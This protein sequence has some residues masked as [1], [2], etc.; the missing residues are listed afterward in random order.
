MIKK[1]VLILAIGSGSGENGV[2]FQ[3]RF[4]KIS[5][6]TSDPDLQ[7]R[8]SIIF[9]IESEDLNKKMPQPLELDLENIGWK[10]T[11]ELD[12]AFKL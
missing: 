6:Q 11:V 2:G 3:K 10:I 8:K 7:H 9:L 4:P 1:D 12:P 5:Q